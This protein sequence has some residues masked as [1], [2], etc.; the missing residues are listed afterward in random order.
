M[1]TK[2]DFIREAEMRILVIQRDAIVEDATWRWEEYMSY[3]GK[4]ESF[5]QSMHQMSPFSNVISKVKLLKEAFALPLSD[6]L[7]RVRAYD[8]KRGQTSIPDNYYSA[9]VIN[10][11]K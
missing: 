7:T 8:E 6:A 1:K 9:I 10:E 11:E 4:I 3:E 5:L 2:E